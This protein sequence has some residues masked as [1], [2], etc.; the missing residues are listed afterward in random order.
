MLRRQMLSE[1]NLGLSDYVRNFAPHNKA[2]VDIFCMAD[3]G[4]T[5]RKWPDFWLS[6]LFLLATLRFQVKICIQI[7]PCR[8]CIAQIEAR[9]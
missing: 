9:I 5:V 7:D 3:L 8:S 1:D 4:Q 6:T 2:D